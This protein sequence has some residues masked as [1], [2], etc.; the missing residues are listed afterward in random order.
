MTP[1]LA[2]WISA[3]LLAASVPWLLPASAHAMGWFQ[4]SGTVH[5]IAAGLPAQATQPPDT[6]CFYKDWGYRGERHCYSPGEQVDVLPA[7]VDRAFSSVRLSG[8]VVVLGY[9]A[10]HGGGGAVRLDQS[11]DHG[12]LAGKGLHDAIRS[13]QVVRTGPGCTKDCAIAAGDA[14]DLDA[15]LA[16]TGTGDVRAQVVMLFRLQNSIHLRVRHGDANLIEISGQ[17][18]RVQ[19]GTPN[20]AIA[21]L[22]IEARAESI[23]I[24]L[25]MNREGKGE[26]TLGMHTAQLDRERR[27]IAATP[28]A[29]TSWPVANAGVISMANLAVTGDEP[30]R[31]SSLSVWRIRAQRRSTRGV[32]CNAAWPLALLNLLTGT[33]AGQDFGDRY[34]Q[35]LDHVAGDLPLARPIVASPSAPRE[36]GAVLAG[37]LH[38]HGKNPLAVFAASRVC[39]VPLRKLL[40]PRMRRGDDGAAAC[41]ANVMTIL[42]LYLAIFQ[43]A[44]SAEHFVEIVQRILTTGSTGYADANPVMEQDL[45]NA[46]RLQVEQLRE[47]PGPS[48]MTIDGFF[49]R[50]YAAAASFA[51][52]SVANTLDPEL[53][54]QRIPDAPADAPT[55][56]QWVQTVRDGDINE[57]WFDLTGF[58]PQP[59]R[60][61]AWDQATSSWRETV[62][63]NFTFTIVTNAN[64]RLESALLQTK[65]KEWNARYRHIRAY[66]SLRR[67]IT[68]RGHLAEWQAQETDQML[69]HLRYI[70]PWRSVHVVARF[71]G[72]PMAIVEASIVERYPHL[73][74]LRFVAVAPSAFLQPI[75]IGS[76]G[77]GVTAAI[78]QLFSVL[79]EQGVDTVVAYSASSTTD[80][81]YDSMSFRFADMHD[82]Q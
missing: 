28:I 5:G 47:Q 56:G 11:G 62:T 55:P 54:A 78:M 4:S 17:R 41:S 48:S 9:T 51:G 38:T 16:G 58:V 70:L 82:A 52:V 37:V 18:L 8:R 77:H 68:L 59:V 64:R 57:Y 53:A 73:A 6:A 14:F 40:A 50:A 45:V 36:S 23:V 67:P 21:D 32:Y 60:P 19:G 7:G 33:C 61:R 22:T 3:G 1:S 30:I 12:Y 42:T 71:R 43:L 24:T 81:M 35:Y 25:E 74:E 26:G 34:Q 49:R 13:L 15:L 79:R 29:T 75:E 72:R 44:T 20:R 65:L 80:A 31:L 39:E 69:D 46:V 27:V 76:A 63:E 66:H 2:G 10:P